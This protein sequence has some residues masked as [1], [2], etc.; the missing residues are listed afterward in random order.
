MN[1]C[2]KGAACPKPDVQDTTMHKQHVIPA[3]SNTHSYVFKRKLN[4]TPQ[5]E[6][7]KHKK[8]TF[9][10]TN[11]N[12]QQNT[13][14]GRHLELQH[15]GDKRPV[16]PISY[17]TNNTSH[18]SLST[19]PGSVQR[20]T[21]EVAT[22]KADS[23]STSTHIIDAMLMEI[24]HASTNTDQHDPVYG[25]VFFC[26][27]LFSDENDALQ[28]SPGPLHAFKATADPDTLYLHQYMKQKDWQQF[29]SALRKEIYD[30]MQDKNFSVVHK[31]KVPKAATVLP[32]VWQLKRNRDV[33][34]GQIKKYKGRL[35]I[36]GSR[37]KKGLHYDDSYA[38]VAKWN[39]IRLLTI[40]IAVHR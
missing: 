37:M 26:S 31:S 30:R 32:A 39:S 22:H 8:V 21:P 18:K 17:G 24:S 3:E 29:R 2:S 23:T 13:S 25:E 34:S 10:S 4:F 27:S 1:T 12:L 9:A 7:K 6:V 36:D 5:R 40:L 35:N 20:H 19:G 38:P 33:K 28:P 16:S 11:E 15:T 14:G